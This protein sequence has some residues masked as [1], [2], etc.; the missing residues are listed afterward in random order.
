MKGILKRKFFRLDAPSRHQINSVNA[1]KALKY[2]NQ[3]S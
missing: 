2:T 3:L 1:L